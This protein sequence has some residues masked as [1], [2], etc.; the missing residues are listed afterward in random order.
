MMALFDSHCHVDEPKFDDDRGDVLTRMAE[1]GVTRYAVIG[2][3]MATSR[4]SADF[5]AAH[6]GCYAAIGIHPHEAKGFVEN[7]PSPIAD[8]GPLLHP[9]F[10]NQGKVFLFS[11]SPRRCSW[12]YSDG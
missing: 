6:L 4:H 11:S 10:S 5:A 7:V 8:F 3:D 1:A 12:K 9:V 2:S